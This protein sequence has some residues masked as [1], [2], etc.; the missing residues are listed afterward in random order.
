[1]TSQDNQESM[2]SQE[3]SLARTTQLQANA[4]AWLATVA[5]SGGNSI[6]S[7]LSAAPP[8]LSER[9]YLA[10]YHPTAAKTSTRSSARLFNSGMASAGLYWIAN[11]S[12]WR[13]GAAVC[14]LSDI[15][16][17]SP[18]PKYSLSA[19]ACSGILRRAEKRGKVLPPLLRDAL[20]RQA[21]LPERSGQ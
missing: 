21:Q 12:E 5:H 13:N 8:G 18:D 7:L 6:G 20:T 1:M 17:A 11:T 14:S 2:F 19:K 10:S 15:L 3:G 16:E 9:M 4:A